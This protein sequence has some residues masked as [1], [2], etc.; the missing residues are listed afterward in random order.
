MRKN[1]SSKR[2]T[3]TNGKTAKNGNFSV[4]LD[5]SSD[6]PSVEVRGTTANNSWGKGKSRT[7]LQNSSKRK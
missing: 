4:T 1:N 7:Q 6:R 5:F 2:F 3:S